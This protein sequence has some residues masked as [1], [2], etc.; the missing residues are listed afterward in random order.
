MIKLTAIEPKDDARLLLRFSDGAWGIHDFS[1]YL[2]AGTAMTAPLRDPRF[3]ASC[4]IEAGALA[5]P[6]GFDLSA[7]SLYL[8]LQERNELKAGAAAA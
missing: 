3:F 6:N 8:R 4:F 7:E 5:W 2:D 1:R